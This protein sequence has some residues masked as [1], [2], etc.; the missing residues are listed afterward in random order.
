[1]TH[2]TTETYYVQIAA[3]GPLPILAKSHED[4]ARRAVAEGP[5][6]PSWPVRVWSE[7]DRQKRR[8]PREW[9]VDDLVEV[10]K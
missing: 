3:V 9:R 6:D 8:A 2:K 5:V 4:A 10:L 1:M 7:E